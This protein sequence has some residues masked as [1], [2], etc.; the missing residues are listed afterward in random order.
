[1]I[2]LIK[3]IF[4]GCLDTCLSRAMQVRLGSYIVNRAKAQGNGDPET[5]GEYWLSKLIKKQIAGRSAV[6]FDVGANRGEWTTHFAEGM[7]DKL[8]LISFEPV[9]ETYEQLTNNLSQFHS[10]VS[11]KTINAALSEKSGST[12]MYI[13]SKNTTA[14]SNSLVE[15][16]GQIYGLSQHK[17]DG[18]T[19]VNGVDF[20]KEN[21]ITHIDFMKIDTEGHEYSVLKGFSKML[22]Q[23]EIDFI[24]FEYGGTWIDS[25]TYLSDVYD[26]LFPCDYVLCRLHPNCLEPFN[27]YDQRQESFVYANYVAVRQELLP[28]FEKL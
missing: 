14:G 25:K 5:N 6:V 21:D 15:R 22:I 10:H 4:N 27:F 17:I 2:T 11:I 7:S 8:M 13:D 1:M 23:R 12:A 18:I 16:K 24:Q 19:L 3:N 20:C 28:I 26:L 9:P